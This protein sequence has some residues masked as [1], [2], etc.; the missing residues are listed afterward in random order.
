MTS[1]VMPLPARRSLLAAVEERFLVRSYASPRAG[2]WVAVHDAL[3]FPFQMRGD[4]RRSTVRTDEGTLRV[5]EIGRGKHTGPFCARLLGSRAHGAG[6]GARPLWSPAALADVDADL[7]LAEIHRW[8]APRFRRAGWL[9]VPDSIRWHGDLTRCPPS[10]A[11]P[12]L[13]AD[14][15]KVSRYGYTLESAGTSQDWA[16][17]YGSMVVP[18]ARVRFGEAAWIPSERLRRELAARGT[19]H[20]ILRDGAPVAGICSVRTGSTLWLPVMG[21][22][23]SDANLLKEGVYSAAFSL[24]F[25]WAA[26]QG[27]TQVDAGRTSAFTLDGVHRFKRKWGLEPVAD[28]LSHLIAVRAGSTALRAFAHQPVLVDRG[29]GLAAF[30]EA[31]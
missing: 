23:Q 8:M 26:R 13:K 22:R 28:P 2:A 15:K 20:F 18:Q 4:M 24:L 27:C 30:P 5:V 9:V 7:V 3:A 25:D 21:L 10:R 1:A 31:E 17:F 11:T 16:E 14:L 6:D 29:S 19:L 12:S